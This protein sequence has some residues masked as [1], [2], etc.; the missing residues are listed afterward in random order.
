MA[1][2]VSLPFSL[3]ESLRHCARQSI[4]RFQQGEMPGASPILCRRHFLSFFNF[5]KK[6][7]LEKNREIFGF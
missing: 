4:R 5:L 7:R 2:S 6:I 1:Q 3:E